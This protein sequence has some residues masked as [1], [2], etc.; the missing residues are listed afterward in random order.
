MKLLE[1]DPSPDHPPS[2]LTITFVLVITVARTQAELDLRTE[3]AI[4]L[5]RHADHNET[6]AIKTP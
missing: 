3:P 6:V 4:S 1:P 2:A 5:P